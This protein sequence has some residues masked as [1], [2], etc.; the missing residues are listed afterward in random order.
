MQWLTNQ[1]RVFIKVINYSKTSPLSGWKGNKKKYLH[2]PSVPGRSCRFPLC[3][4]HSQC[5][6]GPWKVGCHSTGC[7]GWPPDSTGHSACRR[8]TPH[9]W[10]PPPLLEPC[11]LPSHTAREGRDSIKFVCVRLMRPCCECKSYRCGKLW[12]CYGGAGTAELHS[13]S[14]VKIT[15]LNWGD[16]GW[17]G[18]MDRNYAVSLCTSQSPS[19][20]LMTVKSHLL[21]Q[22]IH[23]GCSPA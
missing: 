1:V 16:L 9:L 13:T 4:S 3:P 6:S 5:H 8:R 18:E 7:R 2:L 22:C 20:A 15:D 23:R 21:Y 12:G 17:E 14:Q 19:E 10:T 11:T